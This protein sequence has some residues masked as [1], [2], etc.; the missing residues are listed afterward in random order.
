MC[1]VRFGAKNGITMNF[2]VVLPLAAIAI[3]GFAHGQSRS[4]FLDVGTIDALNVASSP[5]GLTYDVSLGAVPSV[6]I[7]GTT[8][9]IQDLFGFWILS[10]SNITAS[11]NAVA[12]WNANSNNSG[13]GGIAGWNTNPNTG[14]MPNGSQTFSFSSLQA[15]SPTFGFHIR[16]ASGQPGAL[17]GNTVYVEGAPVPEPATMAALGLGLVA[18]ARRKRK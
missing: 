13:D 6:L 7:G 1:V 3:V 14:I 11:Q 8:Y 4:S 5:D 10:D 12:G 18:L 2:K 17:A 9:V 16:L 15:T